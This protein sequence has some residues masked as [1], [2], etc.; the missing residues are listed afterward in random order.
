MEANDL[1]H[2]GLYNAEGEV[3]RY[4]AFNAR[5]YKLDGSYYG[6]V[7]ADARTEEIDCIHPIPL[8]AEIAEKNGFV[9]T[10]RGSTNKL[11]VN[12]NNGYVIEVFF[13]PTNL[14]FNIEHNYFLGDE[15]VMDRVHKCGHYF[16]ELQHA[17]RLCGLKELA[18]N[19][20][21]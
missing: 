13:F 4:S 20:K 10:K 19:L 21:V 9:V 15:Y 1:I 17:L 12:H 3:V 8:T 7:W 18:D 16:H 14:V 2:K 5:L 11:M 6:V